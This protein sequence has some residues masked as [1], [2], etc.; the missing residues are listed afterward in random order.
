MILKEWRLCKNIPVIYGIHNTKTNKWYIGS[1]HNMRDRM[2]R[3]YYY[4]SSNTHHSSKLQNSWN[5]YGE[6]SFEVHILFNVDNLD[7]IFEVEEGYIKKY[8]SKD[9][10]YNM[11]DTCNKYKTFKLSEESGKKVG[12]THS[13][14]II[15]IDRF[16]NTVVKTY[17]SITE[18]S[19]DIHESTSNI[20][21]VCKGRARYAKNLVFVYKEDY[22]SSKDYRVLEHHMKNIPKSEDWKAKARMGN[23]KARII[24]KLDEFGNYICSYSSRSYAERCEGFKKEF[25]R[26]RL[27]KNING[28][29]FTEKRN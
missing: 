25:L 3:H 1:C 11:L 24:Y 17:K 16:T 18:A 10:G 13:K 20:S 28:Y 29:I 23:N 15:A 21:Q 2:R 8:N 5:K 14:P 7:T 22:D 6:D 26:R 12:V 9:G 4:L 19:E 27:D